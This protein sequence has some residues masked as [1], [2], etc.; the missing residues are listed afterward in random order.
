MM[1]IGP[2]M[3]EHRLIERMIGLL[4]RHLQEVGSPEQIDLQFI[5]QAVDFLRV[6]ADRCHHGKEEDFLFKALQEKPLQSEHQQML[7]E[8]L[9]EHTA[10]RAAVR[11][12]AEGR[13]QA[14]QGDRAGYQ[15]I[16]AHAAR[17]VA[18]YPVHIEKEDQVFFLP[19][20]D[21]F[22]A[23]EQQDMLKD[24]AEFDQKM[25]HEKYL[26]VVEQWEQQPQAASRAGQEAEAAGDIYECLVCGYRYDPAA[27]D[28]EHGIAP[29][30]AFEDLP[31]DWLC[32]LC[33]SGKEV[34][35]KVN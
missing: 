31:E 35:N 5:G 20:M 11:G 2:L 16:A 3:I 14:L 6:Y 34:F 30:T 8:L 33:G 32:P 21:Y 17:I 7:D 13:Q 12:V 22:S 1:P 9:A 25:I 4:D 26:A 23:A 27:G 18:L 10:A 15:Q 28:P 24:F 19:V 29:G